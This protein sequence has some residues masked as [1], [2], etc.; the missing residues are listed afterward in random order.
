MLATCKYIKLV[1]KKDTTITDDDIKILVEKSIP[2]IFPEYTITAEDKTQI[3]EGIK[4]YVLKLENINISVNNRVTF[5]AIRRDTIRIADL[6]STSELAKL[7]SIAS[8]ALHA[9]EEVIAVNSYNRVI[10]SRLQNIKNADEPIILEDKINSL[11]QKSIALV[12]ESNKLT[13]EEKNILV[14]GIKSILLGGKEKIKATTDGVFEVIRKDL[15]KVDSVITVTDIVNLLNATSDLI[16]TDDYSYIKNDFNLIA[17]PITAIRTDTTDKLMHY[18]DVVTS[19]STKDKLS[20]NNKF[21]LNDSLS[22]IN[23]IKGIT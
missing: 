3:I 10:A 14:E 7:V 2:L 22:L 16:Y 1:F 15:V 13:L 20:I 19:L 17:S 21:G 18:V 6:V 23:T 12:F 9:A 5:E 8:N 4:S 11:V